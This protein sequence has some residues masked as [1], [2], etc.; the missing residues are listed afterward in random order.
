[1]SSKRKEI[2]NPAFQG[3]EHHMC[4]IK[5]VDEVG[6]EGRSLF[7][8]IH[9]RPLERL[10]TTMEKPQTFRISI[11][12]RNVYRLN[13]SLDLLTNNFPVRL[14]DRQTK[15]CRPDN[16]RHLFLLDCSFWNTDNRFTFGVSGHTEA[17]FRDGLGDE[18][19][20]EVEPLLNVFGTFKGVSYS[21]NNLYGKW[22]MNVWLIDNSESI[23]KDENEPVWLD[24]TQHPIL[25]LGGSLLNL[26]AASRSGHEHPQ[27][28]HHT[29]LSWPIDQISHIS[30][31]HL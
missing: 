26:V 3:S 24:K 17:I 18:T 28:L 13:S 10:I 5:T 27:K 4:S 11:R 6:W 14:N 19:C 7:H 15:R 20:A 25:S 22:W 16:S 23:V 9:Y 31:F 1:M 29:Q 8:A 21:G 12:I 30:A 2:T